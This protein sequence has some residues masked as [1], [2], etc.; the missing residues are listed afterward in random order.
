MPR[1]L[2]HRT[3]A[4]SFHSRPCVWFFFSFISFRISCYCF[5]LIPIVSA[6]SVACSYPGLCPVLPHGVDA[7]C[8]FSVL[9]CLVCFSFTWLI[10]VPCCECMAGNYKAVSMDGTGQFPD[11]PPPRGARTRAVHF[12]LFFPV[13]C[14]FASWIIF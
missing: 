5:H 2:G 6:L 1:L 7:F 9:F 3:S 14:A 10:Q 12:T 8:V 13:L 4:P 11:P